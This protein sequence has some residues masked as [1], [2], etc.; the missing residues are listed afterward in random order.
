MWDD[1]PGS[2]GN[3]FDA[4]IDQELELELDQQLAP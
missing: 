4:G 1:I 3:P 2:R